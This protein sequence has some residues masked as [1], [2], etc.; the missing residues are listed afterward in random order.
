MILDRST[1]RPP[2]DADSRPS[3]T[4]V[5]T[6]AARR[7]TLLPVGT[8]AGSWPTFRGPQASGVADGQHLPDHW[9]VKTGDEHSLADAAIP[10]SGPLQPDRLGRP[11]FLT[12]AVSSDPKAT[13]RPDST[14]TAMRQ[15]TARAIDGCSTPSTSAAGKIA[16]ERAAHEGLPVDKR[17]VKSTYASASPATDGRIVV[18]WFGSQGLHAYDVDG[19]FLWKVDL[20][21][22]DLGAYDIP[23][24]EWGPASSPI[25]WNGFVI[26]PVRHASRLVSPGG[27][28]RDRRDRLEDRARGAA[29]VGHADR[30]DDARWAGAGHQRLELH[31]RLRPADRP[32]AV[33]A[34]GQ[35]ED[36]RAHTGLRDGVF[37]VASGRA[38]ERP[39]FVVRAG[40]RGDLTLAAGA[41]NERRRLPGAARGA[42]RICRPRSSTK[43]CCTCWRTTASSM[44]TRSDRRRGLPPTPATARQWLQRVTG[45]RRRQDLHL[46]R[47]RRH[48]GRR[49]R[50]TSS[51][52]SPRTRWASSLMATPALSDGVMYVRSSGTL[53]AVGRP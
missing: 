26:A 13:F 12:S 7:P 14:A 16:W 18:A 8:A 45:C 51:N 17:H 29:V 38:P 52:T 35:L 5:R 15:T 48:A 28:R 36:H 25:I 6:G 22:I 44:P 33:A 21:R 41:T 31:P 2:G 32:G 40:A 37:V 3:R 20:G 1:W 23:T 34:R 27:Q 50:T 4:L 43:A 24:F 42:A 47:R 9:D 19:Q 49:R 10:G 39:I 53:F 30:G 46:E 11:V